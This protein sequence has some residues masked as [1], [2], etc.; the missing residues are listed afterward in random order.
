MGEFHFQNRRDFLKYFIVLKF[1]F[2]IFPT[3][4]INNMQYDKG[5]EE[6][7]IQNSELFLN[8]IK[9]TKYFIYIKDLMK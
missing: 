7:K 1:D 9:N 6:N 5:T 2:I 3:S 4:I 8:K